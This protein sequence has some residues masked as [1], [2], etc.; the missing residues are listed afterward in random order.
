MSNRPP[1]DTPAMSQENVELARRAYE[2]LGR[3][4]LDELLALVDPEVEWHSLVLEM[5]GTFH[6]HEGV[7]RWW[8]SLHSVFPRLASRADRH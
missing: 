8:T 1:R 6:G 7:R 4:D 2:A 5:E 3:D